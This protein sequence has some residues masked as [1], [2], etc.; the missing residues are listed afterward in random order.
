MDPRA[1]GGGGGGGKEGGGR[2][3]R[4]SRRPLG[5]LGRS[6]PLPKAEQ[7]QA[8]AASLPFPPLL[9]P[10][11]RGRQ[12]GRAGSAGLAQDGGGAVGRRAPLI[13][14]AAA[15]PAPG[16]RRGLHGAG[17]PAL[18]L[19]RRPGRARWVR[20]KEEEEGGETG[21]RVPA[22]TGGGGHAWGGAAPPALAPRG[23]RRDARSACGVL[24]PFGAQKPLSPCFSGHFQPL[25]PSLS[26]VS[27]P[28]P[29]FPLFSSPF[30]S[31]AAAA[32]PSGASFGVT[33]WGE[34]HGETP[35]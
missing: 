23:Q 17:G 7:R 20:R 35:S 5:S 32:A 2:R 22:P 1:G 34:P 12:R 33:F 9:L 19:L 28:R 30:P 15:A 14:A 6:A 13:D 10:F 18:S 4:R 16:A 3:R 27:T 26:P 31:P 21:L 29:L 24:S 25:S 11:P 8:T